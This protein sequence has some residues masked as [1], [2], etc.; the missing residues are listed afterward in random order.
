MG[1]DQASARTSGGSGGS[2]TRSKESPAAAAELIAAALAVSDAARVAGIV[3]LGR[4][5][6][7]DCS[8][9]SDGIRSRSAGARTVLG[10]PFEDGGPDG[11]GGGL[12]RG[13][14]GACCDIGAASAV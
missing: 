13:E 10:G 14:G 9:G 2:A 6:R 1:V 5:A 3:R 11:N 8:I 7:G 12:L 4:G